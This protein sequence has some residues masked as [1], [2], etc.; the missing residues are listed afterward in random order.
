MTTDYEY[1]QLPVPVGSYVNYN[2]TVYEVIGHQNPEDH[3]YHGGD[4]R[5]LAYLDGVAYA[6]WPMGLA[7][8]FGNRASSFNYVRRTSFT[9]VLD[10]E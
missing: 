3:P 2:G 9:V 5:D 8:K 1:G 7:Q 4:F 6:L 10:Q